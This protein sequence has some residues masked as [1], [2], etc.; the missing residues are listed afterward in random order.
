MVAAYRA[1]FLDAGNTLWHSPA[2]PPE[3]LRGALRSLGVQ[4]AMER[5]EEAYR[6][7]VELL[8]AD[9]D[10]LETSGVPTDPSAIEALMLR[11][12]EETAG[13]LGV[14]LEVGEFHR[15]TEEGFRGSRRLYADTEPVL[16]ELHGAYKLAIVSN[17]VDQVE[18]S[19]RLGIDHYFEE[20]IGS[21][22]VGLRKPMPEIFNLALS[23]LGIG[24]AEV[25]MV[26][27]DWEADVVGARAVGIKALHI[28]RDGGPSPG[29]GAITDLWGLVEFLK[30]H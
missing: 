9:W 21:L 25:V 13:A 24:S 1:V 23:A 15:L 18:S 12:T 17:G 20:I 10:A 7:A 8:Q 5:A 14:G 4:V 26:G 19:R 16:Q 28:V 3:I 2:T 11:F 27:D 29:P 22:H 30:A 6:K